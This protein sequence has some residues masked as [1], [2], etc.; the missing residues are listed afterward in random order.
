MGLTFI[1]IVGYIAIA[2]SN[3]FISVCVIKTI[4]SNEQIAIKEL[5]KIDLWREDDLMQVPF[6]QWVKKAGLSLSIAKFENL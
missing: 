4:I 5:Q 6:M 1:F 2:F 3:G